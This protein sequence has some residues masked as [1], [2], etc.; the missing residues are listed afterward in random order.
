MRNTLRTFVVAAALSALAL[1]SAGAAPA[2]VSQR[3]RHL[4]PAAS[5]PSA[6]RGG[7]C[8][9]NTSTLHWRC[10]DGSSWADGNS[11]GSP[12]GSD[13]QLQKKSGSAFSGSLL[14][15]DGT[16]VSQSSGG[17]GVGSAVA[18]PTKLTVF[19]S[20][21]S[22]PRGLM[23]WQASA[24]TSSAHLHMRKSRGTFASPGAVLAGDILGRL[25]YGGYDG[26]SYLEMGSVR[27]TATGTVASTRIPT[28]MEFMTGTDAAP[29]VLTTALTLDKDQ[30]ATF[31]GNSTFSGA[32]NTFTNGLTLGAS[33]NLFGGTNLVE[34]RNGA[35][36]QTMRWYAA[37]TDASNYTRGSLS[38]ST[39]AVT[40]AAESAGTGSANVNVVLTP[41]GT[42]Q[43]TVDVPGGGNILKLRSGN[44]DRVTWDEFGNQTFAN[45][46]N[47]TIGAGAQLGNGT[48][49]LFNSGTISFSGTGSYSGTKNAGLAM[50][51]AKVVELNAGT[52]GTAGVLLLR[53][54]AFAN[55]P[56]SPV[57]G[58]QATVTDSTTTTWGATITGGGS[59][60][61]LAFYNGSAWTVAGK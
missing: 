37:Y 22:T 31:A 14:S 8:Y 28:K 10:Y 35:S 49:A 41:K 16:N 43:L 44:A 23:S 47:L 58:M 60:T 34:Q 1:A 32:T 51:A 19:D 17:F 36:A 21:S 50:A 59:N 3:Q 27:V 2:Q 24:D 7:D 26:A 40:L 25:V 61:V 56:A 6:A 20:S 55:L 48:L 5:D 57:A 39:T 42:G 13:G 38:A 12:A 11:G 29:S 4:P 54:L 45:G 30:S 52:A 33:G 18:P 46:V 15:D 9:Y 53:G